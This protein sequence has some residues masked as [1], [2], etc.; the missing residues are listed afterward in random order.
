[1]TDFLELIDELIK[2]KVDDMEYER[3][4]LAIVNLGL[5]YQLKAARDKVKILNLG[6]VNNEGKS[7]GSGQFK[8]GLVLFIPE[9]EQTAKEIMDKL[10]LQRKERTLDGKNWITVDEK[11]LWNL[12]AAIEKESK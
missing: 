7:Y 5:F 3:D 10:E 12:K 1:M 11:W 4:Y 8:P 6:F 9:E 2:S